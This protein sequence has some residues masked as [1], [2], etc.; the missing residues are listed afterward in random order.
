MLG[1]EAGELVGRDAA[2][3]TDGDPAPVAQALRREGEWHGELKSLRKDGTQVWCLVNVSVFDHPR[4]GEAW[5]AVATDIT[6]RRLAE[7]QMARENARLSGELESA[8]AELQFSRARILATANLERRRIE[9]DL[10]DG[11]Q[12]RLV[13]LRVRLGLAQELLREDPVRGAAMFGDLAADA[14]AALDD[15]RL[16]ARGVYPSVLVDRGL[17]D[18]LRAAARSCPLHVTVDARRIARY[19]EDIE[20][21]VY[22]SCVE[23]LQNAVKHTG[24]DTSVEIA[25]SQDD[26][27]RFDVV[28][29]GG[30]FEVNG[31]PRGRGLANMR[32]RV[33]SVG[34][35]L[36]VESAPGRGTR[37][38]GRIPTAP[39]H[40]R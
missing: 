26:A 7:A 3:V 12:Q 36:A 29:T 25:V 30:G 6:E 23:A 40:S 10:H 32:D 22:F 9:R 5:I 4:H 18:A 21:A 15:I 1:Y 27:L 39:P 20:T 17:G 34:G 33:E 19:P 37:V 28:D 16:L 24:G 11:A 8:L 2:T 38:S 31:R 14:D 35:T 13:A